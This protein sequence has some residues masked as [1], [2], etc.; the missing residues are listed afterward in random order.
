MATPDEGP[1]TLSNDIFDEVGMGYEE[2]FGV[3]E[4]FDEVIRRFI[5]LLPEDALVLDCGC[6][7]GKPLAQMVVDSGRQVLGIDFSQT[8]VDISQK[9]VPG[10]RFEYAD[11]LQYSP[12]DTTFSGIAVAFSLFLLSRSEITSMT[13]KWYDWLAPGG[14]LLIVSIGAE[15]CI[16]TRPEMYDA[17]GHFAKGIPWTFMGHKVALGLFSKAGWLNLLEDVGFQ[18]V[19][20]ETNSFQPEGLRACDEEPQ[21]FLIAKK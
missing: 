5:A 11:M 18:I 2:A 12:Q 20:T 15:D 8:M 10:G 13:R 17:D 7:T 14:H 6:G 9:Q 4:G 16:S 3:N 19:H 1:V 21:L